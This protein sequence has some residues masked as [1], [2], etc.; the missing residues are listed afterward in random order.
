MAKQFSNVTG[1]KN[2]TDAAKRGAQKVID[3][4]ARTGTGKGKLD[5]AGEVLADLGNAETE[6]AG[7]ELVVAHL[8]RSGSR[9]IGA[10][11][12]EKA[13]A[14][15]SAGLP[16]HVPANEPVFDPRATAPGAVPAMPLAAPRRPVPE[17]PVAPPV[18]PA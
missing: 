8:R 2:G 17:P 14:Y 5:I 11:T 3:H 9:G 15:I 13:E 18:P 12:I 1:Q 16:D 7:A 6:L 4:L 10:G